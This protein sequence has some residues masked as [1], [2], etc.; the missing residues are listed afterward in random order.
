LKSWTAPTKVT[1][2]VLQAMDSAYI[3]HD[4][5]GVVLIIGAWNFPVR[6]LLAP[7]VGALAAGNTVVIKP[8]E[9]SVNISALVAELI[10]KYLN[11]NVVQVVQGGPAETTWVLVVKKI[12]DG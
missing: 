10:P 6:L 2:Y 4:P 1:K 11:E 12:D 3:K 8:S 5:L 9:L 7:M